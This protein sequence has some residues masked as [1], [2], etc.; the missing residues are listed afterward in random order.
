MTLDLSLRLRNK[1]KAGTV[2]ER[3]GHY[4][5]GK[6]PGVPKWIQTTGA[7][8]EL[9]KALLTPG[10]MIFFFP[11]GIKKKSASG[12]GPG[13]KRLA[14][15][16]RLRGHFPGM[17]HAHQRGRFASLGIAKLHFFARR[18][19]RGWAGSLSGGPNRS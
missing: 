16:K 1:A 11:R 14:V 4:A 2:A 3:T 6:R 5:D 17:I 8:V 19:D 7:G 9:G 12:L 13:S 10:E 18:R 15:I